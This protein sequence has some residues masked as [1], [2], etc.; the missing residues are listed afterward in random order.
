MNL[1]SYLMI[2]YA[3]LTFGTIPICVAVMVQL[4]HT[5]W[6]KQELDVKQVPEIDCAG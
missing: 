3:L 5:Y 6:F 4:R 1:R 2:F